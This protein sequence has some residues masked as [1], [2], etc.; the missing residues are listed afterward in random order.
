MANGFIYGTEGDDRIL[1]DSLS[2]GVTTNPDG[3]TG[4]EPGYL[5][6]RI[7]GYG[8]DDVIELGFQ[9]DIV[10]G[11][12]GNDFIDARP[13]GLPRPGY[14]LLLSGGPGSDTIYGSAGF[15]MLDG[16][17]LDTV[18][19]PALGADRLIGGRG[20][21]IYYV[22]DARDVVIERA[23]EGY[24]TVVVNGPRVYAMAANFEE[25]QLET[26]NGIASGND[27]DNIM[28][29]LSGGALFGLKG[30]DALFGF[31]EVLVNGG[32]GDDL[33][34]AFYGENTL[35]GEAGD[36]WL[37]VY[38][39]INDDGGISGFKDVLSGGK[40]KD[41][42]IGGA[43]A[44]HLFGGRG[45]DVFHFNSVT[46]SEPGAIDRILPS[47]DARAFEDA[48]ARSGDLIR[49]PYANGLDGDFMPIPLD[50][51]AYVFGSTGMGGI[52]VVDRGLSSLVRVN[53]DDD[54]AFEFKIKIEDGL[55]RASAYSMADF[56]DPF[57]IA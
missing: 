43:G 12:A 46:D 21:D 42:L 55:V 23:N 30:N 7:Y 8:G 41:V 49:L 56:I 2:P 47:W 37:E 44:D 25:L 50:F 54:A 26:E 33:V 18:T 6:D 51:D 17:Y 53:I 19:D 3:L 52:T 24:D 36:D 10:D 31:D 27:L 28:S 14:F 29:N 5:N 38:D 13:V 11:G 48:G 45:E 40:G 34:N 15:D 32:R 4:A 1:R 20:D 22:D 35:I 16:S 9:S 57:L 39:A